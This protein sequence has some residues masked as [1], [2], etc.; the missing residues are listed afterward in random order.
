[1]DC[2]PADI[3]LDQIAAD[4]HFFRISCA[5]DIEALVKSIDYC[6]LL[7]PPMVIDRE[8]RLA[9][10][11]GFG[12]L[13]A[14]DRLGWKTIRVRILN[15][16]TSFENCA[17]IAIIDNSSQRLLNTC[18]HVRAVQLLSRLVS[19]P[20]RLALAARSCGLPVDRKVIADLL[21]AAQLPKSL[22]PGLITGA[23]ALPTAVRLAEMQNLTASEMIGNLLIELDVSLNRQR[24][25]VDWIEAIARREACGIRDIFESDA[26]V[27]L[28]KDAE[29]DRRQKAAQ[30]RHYLRSR[31]FPAITSAER[32]FASLRANMDLPASVQLIAPP[33]FESR[34]YTL[35]MH[36]TAVR[37]LSTFQLALKRLE[38]SPEFQSLWE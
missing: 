8:G 15:P 31:R 14:A 6:G 5:P 21:K 27:C 1:M 23:I 34:S 24:E 26:L 3:R 35:Q 20:E 22:E 38:T 36:V 18:E 11:S 10:V 16:D 30:I 13:A 9:V 12:R 2:K 33:G 4:D 28:R 32:R 7:N 17:R 25:I 29:S 19:E 37:D